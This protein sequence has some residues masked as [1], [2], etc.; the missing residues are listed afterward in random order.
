M[1]ISAKD[2]V[3]QLTPQG[4]RLIVEETKKNY[5]VLQLLDAEP[6]VTQ[7]SDNKSLKFRWRVELSFR[8]LL[9]VFIS[10]GYCHHKAVLGNEAATAFE[11]AGSPK[12]PIVRIVDLMLPTNQKK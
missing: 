9:R 7:K 5:V 2:A 11:Q 4:V 6:I 8:N 1:S 3:T 12:F 10:D